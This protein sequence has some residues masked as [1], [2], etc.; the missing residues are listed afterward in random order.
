[1]VDP[2]ADSKNEIMMRIVFIMQSVLAFSQGFC[3]LRA[4]QVLLDF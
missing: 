4:Y 3:L 2:N 1:M